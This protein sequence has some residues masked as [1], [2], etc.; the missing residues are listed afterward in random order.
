MSSVR[1]RFC[2]GSNCRRCSCMVNSAFCKTRE[3]TFNTNCERSEETEKKGKENGIPNC[4][5]LNENPSQFSRD[6]K[7]LCHEANGAGCIHPIASFS[8]P[9]EELQ[10]W[11]YSYDCEHFMPARAKWR[12]FNALV[13]SSHQGRRVTLRAFASALA[14]SSPMTCKTGMVG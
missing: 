11:L 3:T 13:T 7:S 9:P 2:A 4:R 12:S 1:V 8:C 14:P 10:V 6:C 5:F